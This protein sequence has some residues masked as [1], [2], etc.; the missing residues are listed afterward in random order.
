ME[1]ISFGIPVIATDVGGTG[2]IVSDGENGFLLKPDFETKELA[3]LVLRFC[4]MLEE[5]YA[6]LCEKARNT[7]LQ[8]FEA[9]KNYTLFCSDLT[10]IESGE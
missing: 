5:E 7:F 8:K 6:V 9:E 3:D 1:A 4:E 10:N 2:E